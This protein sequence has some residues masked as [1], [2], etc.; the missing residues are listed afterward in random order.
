LTCL[1]ES[2]ERGGEFV[3]RHVE[4]GEPGFI[5]MWESMGGMARFDRRR[6]WW[7]A[8]RPAFAATLT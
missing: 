6:G 4:A 8:N 5:E 1:D 7:T 3:R 2:I